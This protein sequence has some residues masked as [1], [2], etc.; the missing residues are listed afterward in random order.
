[1][2]GI[3]GRLSYKKELNENDVLIQ[4]M[5]E[6]LE[7]RGTNS[8]RVYI[9]KRINIGFRGSKE[10]KDKKVL[11][12][13]KFRLNSNNYIIV[14]DG[15]IFNKDEIKGELIDSGFD[16]ETDLDSE[17]ILK[18][19]I[20]FGERIC[21]KLNGVFAFVIW[22][23][24][25]ESLILVR[26][27]FGIKPL[28]YT[29]ILDEYIFSSEIKGIL[30]NDEIKAVFDKECMYELVSLGPDHTP[31][32]TI[33]KNIKE[34]K[35][36][37]FIKITRDE[38]KEKLYWELKYKKHTDS[39]EETAD[40]VRFLVEDSIKKQIDLNENFGVLLSGGLDSSIV[41]G[42]VSKY[43]REIRNEPLKTFS[44]DYKD[45]DKNFIKNDFQPN[46]DDEFI[47]IM[48]DEFKTNH[49]KIVLD[50]PELFE[51]LEDA[52]ISKD[53][54]G[55]ADVDT[56]LLCFSKEVKKYVDTVF[57]GEC[58]DEI[59]GGYPWYF[60]EYMENHFPWSNAIK[61]RENLINKNVKD[62]FDITKYVTNRFKEEIS[63]VELDKDLSYLSQN[64]KKKMYVTMRYFMQ[65]L[66]DRSDRMCAYNGLG[67]KVPFCDYRIVEYMWN[68][69]WEMKVYEN[70][71]KGLLR[72]AFR[73]LLP[74]EIIERKKSPYPK[75]FNPSY[76][77][78]VKEELMK[79]IKNDS[80]K[81]IRIFDKEYI[82]KVIQN[83]GNNFKNPWFGQ[84][85]RGP[86]FMAYLIQVNIWLEKYNIEIDI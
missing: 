75:T 51:S 11:E 16:F 53:M 44:V 35:P 10:N 50:T 28:F 47:N 49:I 4:K 15:N 85:M 7:K 37:T 67:I 65:T 83:D 72:Y 24:K 8:S 38:I 29:N 58:S 74:Q 12:S 59:F 55:M 60:K 68:V 30:A 54:P 43:Y 78:K 45:N 5:L 46:Q 80:S 73:D 14:L 86:Q 48:V 25:E 41:T 57:S 39:F 76:L 79:I 52:V 33:L 19:Y 56:S 26:D 66:I 84:L 71:E 27:R 13:F 3:V 36:A 70:R 42:V 61:E 69:P 1:M 2:C 21:E 23:E 18:G 22:N 9:D 62:K 64:H 82:L 17:I 6:K 81:L 34:V 32:K 63:N 20:S 77:E 31:G 40:K